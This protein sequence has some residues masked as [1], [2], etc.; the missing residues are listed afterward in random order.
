MQKLYS[1]QCELSEILNFVPIVRLV[2]L[3]PYELFESLLEDNSN[4]FETIQIQKITF[5]CPLFYPL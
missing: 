5:I 4:K 2:N 3:E 1:M